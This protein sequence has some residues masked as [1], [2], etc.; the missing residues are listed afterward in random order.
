ME[1]SIL[2]QSC[3][4]PESLLSHPGCRCPG[5]G[6]ALRAGCGP[7]QL[8][9]SFHLCCPQIGLFDLEV[10]CLTKILFAA[11]VV[12]ALVMV[13][14]QHFAGRWYLQIIRFLLLFSNI[15]PIRCAESEP[16]PQRLRVSVSLKVVLLWF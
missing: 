12:V 11:L 10:N 5:G 1:P 3:G 9:A 8:T 13:A 15:I 7:Q 6:P 2:S 14:L 16:V 4:D